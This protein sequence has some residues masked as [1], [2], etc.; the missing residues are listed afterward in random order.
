MFS[1]VPA[2]ADI[3]QDISKANLRT[4]AMPACCRVCAADPSLAVHCRGRDPSP[5]R[6]AL[7]EVH[8]AWRRVANVTMPSRPALESGRSMTFRWHRLGR[9][10][11]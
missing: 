8:C 2:K 10:I 11:V 7:D 4:L 9:Y 6:G 1:A 5:V 3:A